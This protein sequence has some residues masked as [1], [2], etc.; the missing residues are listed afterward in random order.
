MRIPRLDFGVGAVGG[1]IYAIGGYSGSTLASVEE[2]DP[3]TNTWR[4][5]APMP[6]PRARLVVAVVGDQIYAIGGVQVQ[7]PNFG[8]YSF[9][10]ELYDP[11]TDTWEQRAP[12]PMDPPFNQFF[13]NAAIGGAA[14]GDRIY[15]VVFNTQTE[16]LTATYEYDP[17]LDTWDTERSPVPFSYTRFAATSTAGKL[18]VAAIGDAPSGGR[19][20]G[21]A[22]VGEYDPQTDIWVIRPST[23]AAR[24]GF[25]LGSIEGKPVAVGGVEI[26]GLEPEET[27][28][29]AVGTVEILD[30]ITGNWNPAAPLLTPRHSPAV[31]TVGGAVYVLGGG[32]TASND[33]LANPTVPLAAVEAAT[34]AAGPTPGD[35]VP[36]TTTLCIDDQPG[37]RRFEV[38]VAFETVQSGGFAGDANAIPLAPLGLAQGGI[39]Y[40]S[41][42]ANPE[43]LIKVINACVPPFDR[44]WVFFSATTNLG[45]TIA[46]TDTAKDLTKT[47]TNVDL[48]P[49]QP[50]QDTDAFPCD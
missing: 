45:L 23:V 27:F 36:G 34:F 22:P 11:S 1:R 50:V 38:E 20:E 14:V 6:T 47:Y 32:L 31:A 12:L 21:G 44:Y 43:L 13:A 2:Y 41:N 33:S 46:V 8:A 29:T 10:N 16:S 49:A 37:D 30:P 24:R 40:F 15:V 5:R 3:L 25:G 17:A 9:A 35:C 42:P 48:S 28:W 39:F 26:A 19:F 4:N 18:F 7:G